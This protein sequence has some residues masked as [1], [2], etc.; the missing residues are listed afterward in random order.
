MKNIFKFKLNENGQTIEKYFV[1]NSPIEAFDKLQEWV[2]Q[3]QKNVA[4]LSLKHVDTVDEQPTI[5]SD[6]DPIS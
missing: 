3:Q 1:C 5:L 4:F 2:I 6:N